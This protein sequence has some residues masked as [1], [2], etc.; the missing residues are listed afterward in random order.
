MYAIAFF[1][2]RSSI[3]FVFGLFLCQVEG[4]LHLFQSVYVALYRTVLM[5][6]IESS[7]ALKCDE[8]IFSGKGVYQQSQHDGRS[9]QHILV[10]LRQLLR[11]LIIHWFYWVFLHFDMYHYFAQY[12]GQSMKCP[13]KSLSTNQRIFAHL[14]YIFILIYFSLSVL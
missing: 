6:H 13:L 5:S 10:Q 1:V 11:L 12:L 7:N 3:S 9:I 8:V 14:Q 2:P 4:S